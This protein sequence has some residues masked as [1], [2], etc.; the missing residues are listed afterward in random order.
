VSKRYREVQAIRPGPL[1]TH[2]APHKSSRLVLAACRPCGWAVAHRLG[3]VKVS[4]RAKARKQ[5][6]RTSRRARLWF[7][8]NCPRRWS[9]LCPCPHCRPHHTTHAT[10]STTGSGSVYTRL[11]GGGPGRRDGGLSKT[12]KSPS[13]L[14]LSCL[15]SPRLASMYTR[16]PIQPNA[17]PPTQHPHPH[18]HTHTHTHTHAARQGPGQPARRGASPP[19]CWVAPRVILSPSLPPCPLRA[20]AGGTHAT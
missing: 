9:L 15:H 4:H 16:R 2:A 3:R 10:H 13:S 11:R 7:K 14:S 1:H 18:T 12:T 20:P 5:Q 6:H 17:P 19:S 8:R